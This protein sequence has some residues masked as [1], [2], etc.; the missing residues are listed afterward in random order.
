M[1]LLTISRED[2]LESSRVTHIVEGV[3]ETSLLGGIVDRIGG[4]LHPLSNDI[5]ICRSNPLDNL[6][7]AEVGL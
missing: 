3:I 1:V 6:S 2:R 7:V 5:V 4:F